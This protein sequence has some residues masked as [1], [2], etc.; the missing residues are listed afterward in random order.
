MS[1]YKFF[2]WKVQYRCSSDKIFLWVEGILSVHVS[3]NLVDVD[4]VAEES[5]NATEAFAELV[6]LR[7]LVC[8]E[9]YKNT[10]LFVVHKKP[11]SKLL[12]RDYV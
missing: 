1:K 2:N 5:T 7:R 6:A 4:L 12:T 10:V 9:L 3:G 8:D 11:V